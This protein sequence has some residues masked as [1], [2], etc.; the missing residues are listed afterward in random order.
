MAQEPNT[1][2]RKATQGI[3]PTTINNQ[4]RMEPSTRHGA[5]TAD[6]EA[7]LDVPLASSSPVGKGTRNEAENP[8]G[9]CAERY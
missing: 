2:I 6:G 9:F 4:H 1:R 5:L 3:E 7:L 8:R